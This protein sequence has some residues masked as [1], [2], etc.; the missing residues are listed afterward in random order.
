MNLPKT[1]NIHLLASLALFGFEAL[2]AAA[3]AIENIPKHRAMRR[4][5]QR[6]RGYTDEEMAALKAPVSM[7]AEPGDPQFT[8]PL[9]TR[10]VTPERDSVFHIGS[11]LA[12]DLPLWGADE[13]RMFRRQLGLVADYCGVLV[14]NYT[15][16]DNHFHLLVKVPRQATRTSLGNE[17]MLR[18][19]G[20]LHEELGIAPALAEALENEGLR[21]AGTAVEHFSPQQLRRGVA[22]RDSAESAFDW[23]TRELERHRE[24]MCDLPSFI[25]LLKQRYARW[26]N[27]THERFGTLWADR[28]RSLLVE[29]TAEAVQSVS[30]YIDLNAVRRGWVE[31]PTEYPFCGAGEAMARVRVTAAEDSEAARRGIRAVVE[32]G[33]HVNAADPWSAVVEGHRSLLW[34]DV[35]AGKNEHEVVPGKPSRAGDLPLRL[36]R[37]RVL[38]DLFLNKHPVFLQGVALGSGEF[39][40]GLYRSNRAAF[41]ADGSSRGEWLRLECGEGRCLEQWIVRGLMVLRNV[42]RD[43]RS[44][45]LESAFG[46]V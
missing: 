30:A 42:R 46:H 5:F 2:G 29:E 10:L 18:R 14:L 41:G 6:L 25:R 3:E 31:D 36:H 8:S 34:G 28:F 16:L 32:M 21:V 24:L 35:S 9:R 22:L 26:F 37:H 33:G 4:E 17:E 40:K 19:I 7:M 44:E 1:G 12:G 15:I 13:R 27:A 20:L 23:G 43:W 11:R 38:A 39:V 45:R